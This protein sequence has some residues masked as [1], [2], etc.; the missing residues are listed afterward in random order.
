[1]NARFSPPIG[2]DPP[3]LPGAADSIAP[4]GDGGEAEK[5][6]RAP[7]KAIVKISRDLPITQSEIEVVAFLL[8]DCESMLAIDAEFAE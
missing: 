3:E 8:G 1:M 5:Q 4:S 2:S 6:P 7:R